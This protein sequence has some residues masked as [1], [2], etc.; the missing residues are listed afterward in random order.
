MAYEFCS[1]ALTSPQ[2]VDLRRLVT[3]LHN[4]D[5]F[6]EPDHALDTNTVQ[7]MKKNIS[8]PNVAQLLTKLQNRSWHCPKI[9]PRIVQEITVLK[10]SLKL[11]P[12]LSQKYVCTVNRPKL[13][14]S[15]LWLRLRPPNFK[16]K[17]LFGL[18]LSFFSYF[19]RW[20]P[21]SLNFCSL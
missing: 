12:K 11:T 1:F 3:F 2:K 8:V 6:Y 16:T 17:T 20:I 4:H 14:F 9:V 15:I 13:K 19:S 10:L 5:S 7:S 18:S 21:Y